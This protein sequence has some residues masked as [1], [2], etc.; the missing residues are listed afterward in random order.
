MKLKLITSEDTHED[1]VSLQQYYTRINELFTKSQGN[2]RYGQ[3][4]MLAL[5]DDLYTSLTNTEYDVWQL[6]AEKIPARFWDKVAQHF[7]PS[8]NAA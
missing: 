4:A 8:N 3:A 7:A 6:S 1:V 2:V 5:P